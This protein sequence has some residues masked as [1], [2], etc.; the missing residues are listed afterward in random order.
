[1]ASGIDVPPDRARVHRRTRDGG[2]NAAGEGYGHQQRD[3]HQTWA[4]EA[5]CHDSRRCGGSTSEERM[6]G[7]NTRNVT[8][9]DADG[10]GAGGPQQRLKRRAEVVLEVAVGRHVPRP[11]IEGQGLGVASGIPD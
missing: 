5:C 6:S 9:C 3:E 7:R 11:M 1:M 8:G 2:T 4:A 10:K